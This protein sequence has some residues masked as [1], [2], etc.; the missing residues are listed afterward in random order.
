MLASGVV[1]ISFSGIMV[2]VTDAP[3]LAIAF[4]RN[5][6]AAAV[7]LPLAFALHGDEIRS[8]SRGE[9]LIAILAGAFLALH[10]A[11]WIPSLSYTTVA[12]S[13][14]LVTTQPVWVAIASGLLL[15]ERVTA[16]A[17]AG[18]AIALAGT[19]IV[20]GGWENFAPS[21]LRM[22]AGSRRF[23]RSSGR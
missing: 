5:A 17:A 1:A 15:R 10:F 8:L 18:I 6:M 14:V 16:G 21:R 12:A 19:A 13:T 22:E 23:S 3:S 11:T 20:A 4:Y 9:V 7:L 2:R